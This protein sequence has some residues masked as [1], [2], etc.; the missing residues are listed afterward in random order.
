MSGSLLSASVGCS[1]WGHRMEA[2][3]I[4]GGD[5]QGCYQGETGVWSLG[6]PCTL[7]MGVLLVELEVLG[8][9]VGGFRMNIVA[10]RLGRQHLFVQLVHVL[11]DL[12]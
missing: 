11:T 8:L 3:R 5:Y 4:G 9:D 2:C 10:G 12:L 1:N 6:G 7:K